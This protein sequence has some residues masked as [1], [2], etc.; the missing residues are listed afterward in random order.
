MMYQNYCGNTNCVDK[1][2]KSFYQF[3]GQTEM[4]SFAFFITSYS[5]RSFIKPIF[6]QSF[7]LSQDKIAIISCKSQGFE[8]S[9]VGERQPL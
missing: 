1:W 5:F 2:E 4:R 6:R 9:V 7:L 8:V 3:Q